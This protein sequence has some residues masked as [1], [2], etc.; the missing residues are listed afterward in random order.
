[1]WKLVIDL[2]DFLPPHPSQVLFCSEST[3][4]YEL[5]YFLNRIEAF[6]N[7][8]FLLI[9]VNRLSVS[10]RELLLAWASQQ[11]RNH[12]FAKNEKPRLGPAHL[13]FTERVG[14]EV[15]F[16]FMKRLM[17]LGIYLPGMCGEAREQYHAR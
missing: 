16:L 5:R 13:I 11:F 10:V 12:D 6:P 3:T 2:C 9:G 7:L 14:V 8:H 4:D 17:K 15:P 1:M